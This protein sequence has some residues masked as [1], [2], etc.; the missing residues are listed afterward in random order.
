MKIK[1]V[2]DRKKDERHLTIR[3][4]KGEE[5]SY[6]QAEQLRTLDTGLFLPFSYETE[7]DGTPLLRYDLVD[8]IT[9]NT[10][11]GA[12][13]SRN[14][15]KTLMI[16]IVHLVEA[17]ARNGFSYTELIFDTGSVYVDAETNHIKLAYVPA[18]LPT[19]KRATIS[20]LLRHIAVKTKFVCKDDRTCSDGLLDFLKRQTIFSLVDFKTFLDQHGLGTG[21]GPL[22][23]SAQRVPASSPSSRVQSSNKPAAPSYSAGFNGA[24]PMGS[25]VGVGTYDFVKAQAGSLSAQETRASKSLAE[26]VSFDVADISSGPIGASGEASWDD[27]A[28]QSASTDPMLSSS[29]ATAQP[30][31]TVSSEGVGSFAPPAVAPVDPSTFPAPQCSPVA[32][33]SFPAPNSPSFGAAGSYPTPTTSS[34]ASDSFPTPTTSPVDLT[35]F[36]APD[37]SA[38]AAVSYATPP[39]PLTLQSSGPPPVPPRGSQ[40]LFIVHV[41]TGERYSLPQARETTIGRSKRCDIRISGNTNISRVHAS[42]K[43]CDEGCY[44]IDEE[45]TN[46]TVVAGVELI[47]HAPY[48]AVAGDEIKLADERLRLEAR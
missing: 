7:K 32:P 21:T 9:L 45:T 1:T 11:L 40:S 48:L 41:A 35:S 17:C 2:K 47:P 38:G 14:Q 5:F 46:K 13:L 3:L 33:G 39:T 25:S 37:A 4:G 34:V 18:V 20:D 10:Y 44:V 12:E 23:P 29:N 24:A 31:S 42:L 8:T 36:P 43:P 16:D 27:V 19:S 30:M 28:E 15:F 22:G 26:Q 6:A